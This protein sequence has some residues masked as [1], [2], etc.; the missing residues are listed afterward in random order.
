M[1]SANKEERYLLLKS[2]AITCLVRL[3]I[4]NFLRDQKNQKKLEAD[5][6]ISVPL[7]NFI[8]SVQTLYKELK[9]GIKF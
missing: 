6:K 4:S 3:V 5:R 8:E 7:S 9:Q 1:G 2:R